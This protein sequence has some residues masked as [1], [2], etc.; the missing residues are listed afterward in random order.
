M[1]RLLKWLDDWAELAIIA[2]FLLGLA[3]VAMAG[4]PHG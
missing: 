3:L 2:L 1:N 4:A